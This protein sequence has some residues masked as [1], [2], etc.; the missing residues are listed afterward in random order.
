MYKVS[1]ETIQNVEE[2]LTTLQL[3][4]NKLGYHGFNEYIHETKLQLNSEAEK[5][6]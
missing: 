3:K 4:L 6:Y 5:T 1:I 2:C